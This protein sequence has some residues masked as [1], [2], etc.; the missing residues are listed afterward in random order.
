MALSSVFSTAIKRLHVFEGPNP[1]KG[2][3]LPEPDEKFPRFLTL[4]EIDRLLWHTEAH[5]R[6]LYFLMALGIDSGMRKGELAAARWGWLDFT[7]AGHTKIPS[8]GG[9]KTKEV[10]SPV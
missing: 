6:D 5:S 7:G 4:D 9:F 10:E 1:C 8:A 3:E 2:V